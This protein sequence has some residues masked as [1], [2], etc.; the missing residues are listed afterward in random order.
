VNRLSTSTLLL[1]TAFAPPTFARPAAAAPTERY[2]DVSPGIRIHLLESG[3]REGAAGTLLFVPGW[4]CAA[5]IW[6]EQLDSFS[7]TYRVVAVDPRSQGLSSVVTD[8]NTP[9]AR[10]GDLH[11]IV[12][13]LALE[14]VVL[15]GWSQGVQ[16]VAAYLARFGG[17]A[18]RGVVLVDSP[19]AA[20]PAEVTLHPELV[21]EELGGIALFAEQ[22]DAY[23]RGMFRAIIRSPLSEQALRD[24]VDASRRTPPDI[25][26]SQLVHDM[27][28]VDRRG[29]AASFAKPVLVVASADSPLLAAQKEMAAAFPH[30][31]FVAVAN[32]A[33]A[34]FVDQPAEFDAHLR[35]FLEG[36]LR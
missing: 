9:E 6:R 21:Q 15:V 31:T 16:D 30:A 23:L 33:H 4:H 24:L 7:A 29:V 5:S 3:P 11:E 2:V 18:L 14:N 19:I 17:D 36:A 22:P 8:G 13:R 10:A 1:L 25:A 12:Q 34:V 32:A 35:E 27:F 20:G 28:T 26:V